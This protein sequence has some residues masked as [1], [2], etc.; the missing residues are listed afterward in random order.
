[1][2]ERICV[3]HA[4]THK[5]GTTSLQY[6]LQANSD[7]L[8]RVGISFSKTG[9][10]GVVPGNHHVAWE[11][12]QNTFDNHVSQLIAEMESLAVPSI[13]LSAE[14][15]SILNLRPENL[16][17]F[18]ELIRAA[19]F[20]PKVLI[21]L[22]D[23]PGFAESMYAERVKHGAVEPF[24]TYVD[25]ILKDGFHEARGSSIEFRY[26]RMLDSFAAAVG[27]E[28]VL[29]RSYMRG[30]GD[31]AIY[32]DF[33]AS[34]EQLVPGFRSAGLNLELNHPRINESLT[35]GALLGNAFVHLR[36]SDPLPEDGEQ[37]FQQWVPDVPKAVL[38]ARFALLTADDISRFADAFSDSN[39]RL[40]ARFGV[41]ISID[42]GSCGSNESLTT[43]HRNVLARSFSLWT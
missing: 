4:G 11:L 33:L 9:W 36:P 14:D 2:S 34:L 43:I 21:Y 13:I 32:H 41:N 6:F 38:D 24:E 40:R 37:F 27:R 22:R 28:N 30:A 39:N 18:A 26:D 7:A 8:S 19:G 17:R 35:F 12:W 20:T 10:Y 31:L 29:G 15:F 23:Q 16:A 3:L 42:N 5:T 25:V 1:M